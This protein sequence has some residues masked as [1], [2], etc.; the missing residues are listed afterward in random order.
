MNR[1]EDCDDD[2]CKKRNK[3]DMSRKFVNE[4][5]P[6]DIQPLTDAM[7][8]RMGRCMGVCMGISLEVNFSFYLSAE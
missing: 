7:A 3:L 1:G 6:V 8:M 2:E 5:V 4:R